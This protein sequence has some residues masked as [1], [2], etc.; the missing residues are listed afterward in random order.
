MIRVLL[1]SVFSLGGLAL[2]AALAGPDLVTGM[3][4]APMV[5]NG[6]GHVSIEAARFDGDACAS[7]LLFG[8]P[9]AT[10]DE[11]ARVRVIALALRPDG[12]VIEL[13]MRDTP[14]T[15]GAPTATVA[16]LFDEHGRLVA[17]SK[18]TALQPAAAAYAPCL[19]APEEAPSGRV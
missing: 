9:P 15:N 12:E 18:P 8:A 11:P 1:G 13:G 3:A 6:G 14:G 4:G 19:T 5:V 2:A 10:S 16:I 7:T 17:I